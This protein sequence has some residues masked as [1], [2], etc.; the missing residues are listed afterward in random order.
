[1][2]W[3]FC[4]LVG[5]VLSGLLAA[6]SSPGQVPAANEGEQLIQTFSIA[7]VEPETGTCGVAVASRASNACRSVGHARAGV[8]AVCTQYY[9]VPKWG[10]IALDLLA[11]GK[12]PEEVSGELLRKDKGPGGRQLAIIDIE[13]RS[14][15]RHP[16]K[17]SK[18]G[19]YWGAMTGKHYTCQGNTLTGREV[20][21]G[22]AKAYEETK[23]SMADRLM[24][25]LVAGDCAGG[26]H[27]G[28]LAAGIR[29]CKKGVE[30]YWLDLHIDN[31]KDAVVALLKA[32]VEL[33]HDAKGDWPGGQPPFK[34]P[35]PD[36]PAPKPPA[37]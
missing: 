31:N 2:R 17:A 13:G 36:R 26:D 14:C 15:V 11:Q 25:A 23:G 34:H 12:L 8:G 33:K 7:A 37:K 29:V 10:A 19:E 18:S 32:Y 35:C 3:T 9:S 20:I 22:M 27:R 5:V 28:R 6:P 4:A 16:I 21:L 1:M 24:A 30:G